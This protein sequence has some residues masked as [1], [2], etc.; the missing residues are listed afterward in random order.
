MRAWHP[1]WRWVTP[2]LRWACLSV[3]LSVSVRISNTTRLNF[4]KFSLRVNCVRGS[5]L[6]FRYCRMF[7]NHPVCATQHIFTPLIQVVATELNWTELNSHFQTCS[8]LHC[9]SKNKAHVAHYNCNA[10]TSTDFGNLIWPFSHWFGQ[11]SGKGQ[12]STPTAPKR[13]NR[14]WWN[15]NLR[16]ISWRP[17]ITENVKLS[18]RSDDVGGLY[19]YPAWLKKDNFRG[20]CF[21]R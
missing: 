9:V 18:F 20:S 14:F 1:R 13:L 15:S 3:C 4:T 2:M 17:A 11:I 5:V 7:L 8:Q 10:C 6:L 16:T 12:I 21:P 19:Q